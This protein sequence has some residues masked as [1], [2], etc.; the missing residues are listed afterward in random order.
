MGAIDTMSHSVDSPATGRRTL[1]AAVLAAITWFDQAMERRRSRRALLE[2]TDDQL[3]DIGISRA[4]A[5]GEAYRPF[6]D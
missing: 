2:L 4:Q 5:Y 3:K 6:W 1:G